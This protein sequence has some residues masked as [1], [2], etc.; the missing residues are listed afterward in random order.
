VVGMNRCSDQIQYKKIPSPTLLPSNSS[1]PTALILLSI[2]SPLFFLYYSCSLFFLY[3]LVPSLSLLPLFLFL[4][5]LS[6]NPAFRFLN[7]SSIPP[8][9]SFLPN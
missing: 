1:L 7:S 4:F 8:L 6:N 5:P 9:S 3:T 2:F